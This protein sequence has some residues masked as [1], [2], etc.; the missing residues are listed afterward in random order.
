MR[1]LELNQRPIQ[2]N[3]I[4]RFVLP[5]RSASGQIPEFS[6]EHAR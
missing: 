2:P 1:A 6:H 3:W 4:G 5:C